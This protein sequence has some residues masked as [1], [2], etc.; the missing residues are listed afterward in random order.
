MSSLFELSEIAF[1]N[2]MNHKRIWVEEWKREND[3]P[4]GI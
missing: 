2:L 1:F 3:I 4:K